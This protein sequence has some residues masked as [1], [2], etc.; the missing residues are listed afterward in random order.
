[1]PGSY[2]HMLRKQKNTRINDEKGSDKQKK[3]NL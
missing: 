3:Q 2:M 1:M